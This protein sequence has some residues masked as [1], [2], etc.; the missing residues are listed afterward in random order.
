MG[1]LEVILLRVRPNSPGSRRWDNFSSSVTHDI[2]LT[3]AIAIASQAS[4]S[5]MFEWVSL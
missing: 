4:R 3:E 1:W 2:R 5:F